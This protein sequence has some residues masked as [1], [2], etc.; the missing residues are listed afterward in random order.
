MA[1]KKNQKTYT[2]NVRSTMFLIIIGIFVFNF[3]N[4]VKLVF[5]GLTQTSLLSKFS[6]IH[7]SSP[8]N[9]FGGGIFWLPTESLTTPQTIKAGVTTK[10]CTKQLRGIYYNAARGG[11]VWPLDIKTLDLLKKDGGGYAGLNITGG[12]Y[13]ACDDDSYGVYGYIKYIWGGTTSH[14]VAGTK[15]NYQQNNFSGIFANSFEYFNNITPLGYIWDSAGGIGFIGGAITGSEYLINN[16][17]NGGSINSSF[18]ISGGNIISNSPNRSILLSGDS[19]AQDTMWNILIQGSMFIGSSI[20]SDEK[21]ALLGNIEKRTIIMIS[22]LNPS[23]VINKAKKNAE[24]LCRGKTYL[25]D[26]SLPSDNNEKILCYKDT[27][28]NINLYDDQSYK[29]KTIIMKNGNIILENTMNKDSS[30]LDVFIDEGN[31]YIKN[32]PNTKENFN[33]DGY[34]SD[35]GVTNSG[36]FI[37][38]NFVVNGLLIGTYTQPTQ[39]IE[40]KVHLLGR[41]AFLNTPTTPS[42]GRIAQI[43]SVLGTGA[44]DQRISLENVFNWSCDFEGN[45]SD[46]TSCGN[47]Y[48]AVATTPFV[49]L[50]ANY[51]SNIIK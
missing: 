30:S 13:T 47:G 45:A 31:L 7:F 40:H 16:I 14:I 28:L 1:N 24:I 12:F 35:I 4:G 11:R 2:S 25:E 46:G 43:N 51:P 18:I 39:S 44:F 36:I 29:G 34:P 33:Q 10:T 9:S 49:V 48:T 20:N 19:Q 27:N 8:G 17:N 41:I 15:M 22:D 5:P 42:D 21:K 26:A 50:N 38:G 37:K 32:D 3:L 23:D 6:E